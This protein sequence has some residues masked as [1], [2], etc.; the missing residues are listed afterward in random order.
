M[1]VFRMRDVIPPTDIRVEDVRARRIAQERIERDA[2]E[3]QL[4]GKRIVPGSGKSPQIFAGLILEEQILVCA[5]CVPV[6]GAHRGE[7]LPIN[8]IAEK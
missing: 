3:V 4:S 1:A 7:G 5:E 8:T 2:A 6:S